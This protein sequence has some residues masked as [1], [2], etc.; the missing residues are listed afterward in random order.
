[1]LVVVCLIGAGAGA[2]AGAAL[3]NPGPDQAVAELNLWRAQLGESAVSTTT[4]P[5]WNTGCQHHDNYESLNGA[6]LTHTEA[7]GNPG[8][9]TDG[10]QAASDSVLAESGGEAGD[11]LLP[12][13]TWDGGVFHRADLLQPRLGQVGFDSSSFAGGQTFNCLWL[14]NQ[15]A[16]PPQAIDNAR[17]TP[18]LALYPSPASGAY[19]VPTTFPGGE[20]PDPA[21]ETGVPAGATLGWLLNVE[22]N[23]PWA[24]GGFGFEVYAHDVTATLAPDGTAND[25]PLVVSECG[26]SGCGGAGGTSEGAYFQGGFGLFPTQPL[27]ANTTYRVMLTGGTV[28]DAVAH[29]DYPIPAGYSWCFSTGPSYTATADCAAPTTAA[30][31]VITPGASTVVGGSGGGTGGTGGTGGGSGGGSGGSGSGSGGGSGSGTVGGNT[32]PGSGG[33]SP[34]AAGLSTKGSSLT[35]VRRGKPSLTLKLRA[36]GAT[37]LSTIGIKPPSG[38]TVAAPSKRL[39]SGLHVRSGGHAVRFTTRVKHGTLTITLR[40]PTAAVQVTLGGSALHASRTLVRRAA[41][42]HPKPLRFTITT[43]ARTTHL[44]LTPR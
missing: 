13:P 11:A 17:T 20:A 23:G 30:A 4:V 27:A 28:T 33:G 3:A 6:T 29:V 44:S 37:K 5:A 16:S 26:S 25:V 35:G 31:E 24:T 18:T 1:M 21:A 42:K 12:G 10:A 15:D 2:G 19:G 39:R 8:Y 14:L 36:T 9:T 22:I 32:G 41:V 7:M 34:A 40:S 43:K 38:L